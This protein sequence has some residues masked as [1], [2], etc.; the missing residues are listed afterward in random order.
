MFLSSRDWCDGC[1]ETSDSGAHGLTPRG[2]ADADRPHSPFEFIRRTTS[3]GRE[4]WSARELQP[5]L[6]YTEWRKFCEAITRARA[7]GR[8]A[9]HDMSRHIVGAA[10][11]VGIGSGA[12]R[13]VEDHHLSRLACY[14]IA[15]N[16]DPRKPQVAAA[17]TYFAV[18]TREAEIA[19]PRMP[20]IPQTFA[21]ALRLA[22]DEHERAEAA[23]AR[24]RELAAPAAAWNEL[25]EAAGD[26]SVADC[27]KVLSRD[28]NINIGQNRLF[29]FMAEQRWV[30]KREYRWRAYQEQVDCGRLVEKVGKPFVRDGEIVNA[31]PTVRITPKGLEEL[32]HRLGGSGQLE[33]MAVVS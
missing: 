6:G 3:E 18:R 23:E 27:A 8:N 10:K 12:Q 2:I 31:A 15:M 25:A 26:Y 32:H 20:A 29:G 5:L 16:G 17:Q 14:L 30:F 24:A 1:E 13:A 11:M 19:T 9:G 28:P 7:S 33:L 4:W 21:E 22:A